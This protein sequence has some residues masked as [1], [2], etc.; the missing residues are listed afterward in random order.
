MVSEIV[1]VVGSLAILISRVTGKN[2]SV[3][4]FIREDV[5]IYSRETLA[6]L[7]EW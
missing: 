2:V 4:V 1:T 3:V 6:P 5:I 7:F